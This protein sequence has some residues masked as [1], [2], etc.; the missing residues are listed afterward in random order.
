MANGKAIAIKECPMASGPE[1]SMSFDQLHSHVGRKN[2]RSNQ[3][4]HFVVIGHGRWALSAVVCQ[5]LHGYKDIL[6]DTHAARG[7]TAVA[8]ARCA[9]AV[10]ARTGRHVDIDVEISDIM[11]VDFRFLQDEKEEERKTRAFI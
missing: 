5:Y 11:I 8:A 6:T 2:S 3:Q 10:G 9:A 7:A 4:V 1:I